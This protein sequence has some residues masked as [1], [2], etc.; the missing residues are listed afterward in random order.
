MPFPDIHRFEECHPGPYECQ[1]GDIIAEILRVFAGR[2][3]D[4]ESHACVIELVST[5]ARWSAGHVVFDEVRRRLLAAA[6]VQD[7]TREWQYHFE[8]SCCQA[9]YNASDPDDPFD[10]GSAF[11]I[12]PQA[13]GLARC[14]GVPVAA[15]VAA[16]FPDGDRRDKLAP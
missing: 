8:E 1:M 13:I 14:I 5:P 12:F 15:I 9:A 16:A 2:M 3:P 4:A 10:P 6:Q 11:F 7:T